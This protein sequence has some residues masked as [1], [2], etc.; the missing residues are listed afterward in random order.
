VTETY[1]YARFWKCALQVNPEGYSRTYRGEDHG[2]SGED[3]LIALLQGCKEADIQVVGIADHG[4]VQDVDA[5]RDFLSPHG[6]VVFPGFEVATTEK[7]HWVCLFKEDTTTEQLNRYLGVLK[8]TD[9]AEGVRPSKLG[10]EELLR[11]VEE[12]CHGFCYAAHATNAN[13]VLKQKANH[14]WKN[15]LLK[16]A[17]IPGSVDELPPEFKK[18]AKNQ[19]PAYERDAEMAFI[20]AKDVARPDDLGD[21][22][23]SC[24]IKMTSPTFA[25]F[26]T[27]FKD[28]ESRVR[29]HHQMAEKHY[30]RIENMTV[31]GGYLDEVTIELSDHLNTAIG[32]RGTGK[33]TLLECLRYALDVD[34]KG[35]EARR[36]GD[37][38]VKENLGRSSGR[39]ELD[40]VS[41]ANRGQRYR[42]VR[43]YGEPPRVHD[44]D[45]NVSTL[46]PGR[47]LLP[48]NRDLRPERDL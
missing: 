14:L 10:G 9:P 11:I 34:H 1:T 40:I 8:L 47:D 41:A 12:E 15:S 4:S 45:G 19:D 17:Q 25:S 46:Y 44:S 21:P 32:G 24:Y 38:I 27:A 35:A 30:S 2:L 20:N 31:R 29:L 28:P 18:I 39:V 48:R 13:G 16:A 23:A 42:V 43:R 3:F 22:S 26:V 37:Q 36:Q 33:S 7:V 6:I 5:I